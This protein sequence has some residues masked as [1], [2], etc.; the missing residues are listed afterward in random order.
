MRAYLIDEISDSG[1]EK[2]NGFLKKN[3]ITSNL[4]QLF[5]VPIPKTFSAALNS[6]TATVSHML[7]QWNWVMTG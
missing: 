2:I 7:L 6:I 3:A 4:D 5:W 1:M